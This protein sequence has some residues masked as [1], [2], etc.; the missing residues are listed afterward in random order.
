MAIFGI[1]LLVHTHNLESRPS[2][3][4]SKLPDHFSPLGTKLYFHVNSSRKNSI[5]W[6]LNMNAL[7]RGCKPRIRHFHLSNNASYFSPPPPP[8][9][10]PPP[11]KKNCIS[12]VFDFFWDGCNTQEKSKV[13]QNLGVG[14]EGANKVHYGKCGSG[15]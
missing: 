8:P 1:L 11:Q 4:E 13:M 3:K 2:N 7:S 12:I 14:G 5:V 9:P 15:V 6:T 10:P